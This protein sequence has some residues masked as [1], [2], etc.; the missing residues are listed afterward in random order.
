M[1]LFDYI[2]VS[3]NHRLSRAGPWPA[4]EVRVPLH[5]SVPRR[6]SISASR[7]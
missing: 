6:F 4:L 5:F 7:A 2:E 1:E 3:Y